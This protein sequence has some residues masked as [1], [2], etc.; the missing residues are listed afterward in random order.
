MGKANREVTVRRRSFLLRLGGAVA[1]APVLLTM[2][3]CVADGYGDTPPTS[4]GTGGGGGGGGQQQTPDRFTVANADS[5]G[6]SHTFEIECTDQGTGNVTYTA[7]GGHTHQV[8]LTEDQLDRVFAG[9]TVTV[10]TSDG[11]AHTWSV[12]MPSSSVC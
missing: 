2:T 4:N 10:N 8:A 9:E 6:H 7:G 3:G 1:S 11:H 12:R 5:S